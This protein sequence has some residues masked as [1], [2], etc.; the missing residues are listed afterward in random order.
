LAAILTVLLW[1]ASGPPVHAE[2]RC[3]RPAAVDFQLRD[4]L[5]SNRHVDRGE[6]VFQR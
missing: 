2:G 3:V 6:A 1:I 4:Y 5:A